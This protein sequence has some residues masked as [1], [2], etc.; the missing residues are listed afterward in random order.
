ME[1]DA[2]AFLRAQV[3]VELHNKRH[4]AYESYQCSHL[5]IDGY[6]YCVKHILNDKNAPY[7]QCNFIYQN[8]SKRCH[9]PAPKSDRKDYGY[10]NEHS[11]KQSLSRNKQNGKHPAPLTGETLLTNLVHH[12]KKPRSKGAGSSGQIQHEERTLAEELGEPKAL[13]VPDP[14]VDI[15]APAVFNERCSEVLDMCSESES[16]IEPSIY[17]TVWH[18]ANAESSDNESIDSEDT[19]PMK[20]V[21]VYTEEEVTSTTKNKLTRLQALYLEEYKYLRYL[22]RERRRKYIH[23]LKREKETCCNIYNQV[24]DDPKEQ[25]LYAKLKQYNQYHRSFGEDA[26]LE[27]KQHELRV[28]ATEGAQAKPPSYPRC[29]FTEGGVKCS[30]K[31]LPLAKHCRK[32]ILEDPNQVL[33]KACGKTVADIECNTPVEAIFDDSTCKLHM[34]MPLI[35]SYSNPRTSQG[36]KYKGESESEPEDTLDLSAHYTLPSNDNVKTEMIDYSLPSLPKMESLPSILFEDSA[37]SLSST[38]QYSTSEFAESFAE[39]SSVDVPESNSLDL[40]MSMPAET[41]QLEPHVKNPELLTFT[42]ECRTAETGELS[43]ETGGFSDDVQPPVLDDYSQN[44]SELNVELATNGNVS[45]GV[46][47]GGEEI[48]LENQEKMDVD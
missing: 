15:D 46:D 10:C 39:Q 29:Q 19:D 34:E 7:K 28:K 48:Y 33:F 21:N 42:G 31:V 3:E 11:L 18:D 5:T 36:S 27:R 17:A 20:H 24:R 40:D 43:L 13:K 12:V 44:A 22:L 41:Q 35:R 8:N 9:L 4:C 16:D 38:L 32:H 37:E 23:A 45:Q 25:R 47:K 26:I 1:K 6:K 14:F 2:K 30:E